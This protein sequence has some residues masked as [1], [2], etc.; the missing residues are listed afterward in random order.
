MA[1]ENID[2]VGINLIK[3]GGSEREEGVNILYKKYA[4]ILRAFF[5]RKTAI[6]ADADD[7]VQ[8]TFIKIVKG[9]ETYKGDAP[10]SAWIRKVA[11]NCLIDHLRDKKI[12]P[13]DHF[14]D[15]GWE[16]LENELDKIGE[17]D[18]R[19][20]WLLTNSNQDP[21]AGGDTIEKCVKRAFA[22]FASDDQERAE[23]LS[24]V[25]E[26]YDM[27][28]IASFINRTE[29]ATREYLSQCRKK[30]EKY[31]LPCKDLLLA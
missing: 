18:D 22:K 17:K 16:F 24:L 23:A 2:L 25:V 27:K 26:G 11:Q 7:L 10:L 14:S 28:S 9:C 29:G 4:R 31:M 12:H 20:S 21:S 6:Q 3:R 30:I 5:F 13:T 15:E 1:E 8:E 19:A